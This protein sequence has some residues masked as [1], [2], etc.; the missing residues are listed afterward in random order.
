VSWDTTGGD[1]K[2]RKTNPYLIL[3]VTKE[4]RKLKCHRT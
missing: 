1:K 2:N 4:N 3:K